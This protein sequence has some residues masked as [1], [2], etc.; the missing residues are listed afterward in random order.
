MPKVN[1][2]NNNNN[3]NNN[4]VAIILQL[5]TQNTYDNTNLNSKN[6][7]ASTIDQI[8][9]YT[10]IHDRID[11]V[12]SRV[13]LASMFFGIV[14]NL[15]CICVFNYNKILLKK[16]FNWYLFVLACVDCIFCS[17]VFA[18]Y[19]VFTVY[20]QER[21]LYDLSA[22]T[23]YATDF[24]VNSVDEYSV[25]L[26]LLLSIDRLYAIRRPINIKLFVTYRYQKQVTAVGFAIITLVSL[27][28]FLL[29]QRTYVVPSSSSSNQ[30][31]NDGGG[32]NGTDSATSINKSGVETFMPFCKYELFVDIS[33]SNTW[34]SL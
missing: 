28:Y 24:V 18:N 17:I 15:V 21:A 26:T 13:N 29:S 12:V 32:G 27:P 11:A 6:N 16:R 20:R 10:N 1:Y 31:V 25:L 23:C 34:V 5:I 8:Q 3:N 4:T 19:L 9:T 30:L 33:Q 22:I 14:A 7:D 2:N